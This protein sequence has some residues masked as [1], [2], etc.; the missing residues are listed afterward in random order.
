MGPLT[1]EELMTQEKV[2]EDAKRVGLI[3]F[4]VKVDF[5][6]KLIAAA[7]ASIP[8]PIAEA[9]RDGTLIDVWTESGKRYTD[10]KYD[11]GEWW[12]ETDDLH[13]QMAIREPIVSF[14]PIPK[15]GAS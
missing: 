4:V 11:E 10:V 8:R 6:A 9:P 2:I 3:S 7:R 15:G 5:Y 13:M 1:V 12:F 14:L